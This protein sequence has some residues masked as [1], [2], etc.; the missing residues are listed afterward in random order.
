MLSRYYNTSSF[1]SYKGQNILSINI[2][3]FFLGVIYLNKTALNQIYMN[4]R[5]AISVYRVSRSALF[6]AIIWENA[7]FEQFLPH[8]RLIKTIYAQIVGS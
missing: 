3:A 5:V 2:L 6:T 8:L 4:N 1:T 7:S